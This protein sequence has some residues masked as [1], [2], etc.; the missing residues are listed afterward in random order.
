MVPTQDVT[1]Q[2]TIQQ[3]ENKQN[4]KEQ[5]AD[6]ATKILTKD[7]VLYYSNIILGNSVAVDQ[8]LNSFDS[9]DSIPFNDWGVVSVPDFTC[10]YE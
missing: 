2:L 4:T 8:S 9:F 3:I 7:T 6:I 5:V 1:E 10:M